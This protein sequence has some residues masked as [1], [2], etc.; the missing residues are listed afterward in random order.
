MLDEKLSFAHH[1]SH[2]SSKISR[3]LEFLFKLRNLMSVDI[4]K[5]LYYALIFL[6]IT[7]VI[8][9][10]YGAPG[11]VKKEIEILQRKTIR[12]IN[13]LPYNDHT[14]AHF[15]RMNSLT[16]DKVFSLNIALYMY[17]SMYEEGY[18]SWLK[19]KLHSIG[20]FHEYST[21]NRLPRFN[22]GKT[23]SHI[24]YSGVCVW[25]KIPDFIKN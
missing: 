18:D 15:K 21:R 16:V 25:N 12:I 7:Y 6:Y 14:P 20:D 13:F 4:M 19:A 10:W 1:V 9:V 8:E 22:K 23:K 24:Q 17:R 3:T 11:Y 5:S 2:L